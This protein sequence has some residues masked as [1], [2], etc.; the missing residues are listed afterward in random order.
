MGE[1]AKSDDSRPIQNAVWADN[2]VVT[3]VDR[4]FVITPHP[5]S[6]MEQAPALQSNAATQEQSC[7]SLDHG[8]GFASKL[9]GSELGQ[10]DRKFFQ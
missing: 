6:A 1:V 9:L 4:P 5:A 8:S 2:D 3:E 7:R 10:S